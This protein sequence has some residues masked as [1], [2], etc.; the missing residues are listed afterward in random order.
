MAEPFHRH[1]SFRPGGRFQGSWWALMI[2]VLAPLM[3]PSNSA[4]AEAV[5]ERLEQARQISY[6]QHWQDAQAILDELVDDLA[7]FRTRDYVDFRLLEARHQALAGETRKALETARALLELPLDN[8]QELRALQ[9]SANIAVLLREYEAAFD[10]LLAGLAIKVDSVDSAPRI[11]TLNM[12]SYM[13]GRVAEYDQGISYGERALEM[14]RASGD[15]GEACVA[16]QRLAPVYKWADQP[17]RAEATYREGISQCGKVGNE[18]FV[19][20]LQHGLA[21]LLRQEGRLNEARTLAEQAVAALER[22]VYELGEYEARLVEAE[23]L[24]DLGLLEAAEDAETDLGDLAAYFREN[25]MWDQAARLEWLHARLSRRRGDLAGA[26]DRMERYVQAREEFLGRERAMR[27]AYLQ[28]AFDTVLKEQEIELLTESAR[29]ARLETEAARQERR[30]RTVIV[31]LLVAVF[32]LLILLLV[33]TVRSRQHFRQ[34]SRH[35]SLSGLAN[36]AWF[37]EQAAELLVSP[38]DEDK[39]TFLAVA[40]IDHFK[41][42]NDRYGH[43]VGDQVIG[44]TARLLRA[45]FGPDAL[46]GRIGGEEFAVMIRVADVKDVIAAIQRFAAAGPEDKRQDD[47]EVTVSFGIARARFGDDVDTLRERADSALYKAK[48]D[49][50]NRYVVARD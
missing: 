33:R 22:A 8:D 13:F 18:L 14:A 46:T 30:F 38:R 24:H 6:K 7:D 10:Y 26:L 32:S 35:D 16:L 21:D 47:P 2:A 29:A 34:L 20:V 42:V 17:D 48:R 39:S 25:N 23:V 36:R 28:V 9:F 40:D 5:G 4:F 11:A 41:A 49:G 45:A 12:A 31:L 19:G 37:F 1:D 44:R 15:D 50:R 43:R 3:L 27:L